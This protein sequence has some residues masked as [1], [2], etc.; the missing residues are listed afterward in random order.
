MKSSRYVCLNCVYVSG[1]IFFEIRKHLLSDLTSRQI[2]RISRGRRA[3][4]ADRT[5][6]DP[7]EKISQSQNQ[8][9]DTQYPIR[10]GKSIECRGTF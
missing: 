8:K 9:D 4:V 2:R 6:P 3:V 10:S 1:G 7:M 5:L